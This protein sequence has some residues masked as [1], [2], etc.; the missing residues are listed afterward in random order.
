[1]CIRDRLY[2]VLHFRRTIC[3]CMRC[4][5]THCRLRTWWLRLGRGA[6]VACTSQSRMLGTRAARFGCVATAAPKAALLTVRCVRRPVCGYTSCSTCG[7]H[8][9]SACAVALHIAC[10]LGGCALVVAH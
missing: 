8:S 5:P 9:A 3:Q 10:A 2:I 4:S 6:Q 7:A 1:M